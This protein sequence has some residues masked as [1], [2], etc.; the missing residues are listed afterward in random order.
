M[1]ETSDRQLLTGVFLWAEKI[2]RLLR[3]SMP[4]FGTG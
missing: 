3:P 1:A 4:E 2:N